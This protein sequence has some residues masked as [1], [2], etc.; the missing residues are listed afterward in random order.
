MGV[1]VGSREEGVEVLALSRDPWLQ[2]C[3]AYAIGELRLSRFAAAVDRWA[4]DADPL[5]R[6]TAQAAREKLKAHAAA[7]AVDVG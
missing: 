3:A 6:A 7:T 2:S 1:S 5:L 4:D